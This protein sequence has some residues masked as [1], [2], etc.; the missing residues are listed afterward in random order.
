MK[1]FNADRHVGARIK[2]LIF[3]IVLFGTDVIT[4]WVN[5]AN[6]I[7]N[8]DVIWGG[9]MVAL[10]FLPTI[11]VLLYFAFLLL[12][13][14]DTWWLGLFLLVCLL[15]AAAL[16]TPIY[17]GSILLAAL[18]R[19]HKPQM[20]D[21]EK[22]LSKL[23]KAWSPMLRMVEVVGESYPQAILGLFIQWIIGPANG[24]NERIVQFVGITA[25]IVSITKGCSDWWIRC[26]KRGRWV[27]ADLLEWLQAA[28]YFL[29]HVLFRLAA[30]SLILA[31]IG[32]YS[33]A[34]LALVALIAFC[35][36]LP[37]VW[38]LKWEGEGDARI[39][40]DG[41]TALISFIL[42]LLAP[43][44][45]QS[46]SPSH[47]HLM[48]RTTTVITFSL[49]IV[50]TLIRTVPILVDPDTLIA[51]PGLCH[52]NFHQHEGLSLIQLQNASN[53]D[54]YGCYHLS[55]PQYS[56]KSTTCAVMGCI[57]RRWTGYS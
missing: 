11:I 22:L 38:K 53:G 20:G 19:L 36:A 10:P 50:L 31:F 14:K 1:K 28:V 23:V 24:D 4:D 5:G 29:P 8:G 12:S 44:S 41:I 13:D 26:K 16:C 56:E 17:I 46:S 48:K 37:V 51:T 21:Q 45:F 34:L 43:I 9:L 6:L 7:L 40:D 3:D 39:F 15:P 35:L 25:S 30:L 57:N 52:L 2:I 54:T 33:I 27:E 18:L 55:L 32:F 42:T 47:R 49:L